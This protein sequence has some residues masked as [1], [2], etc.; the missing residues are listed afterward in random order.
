MEAKGI[1]I[2]KDTLERTSSAITREMEQ[3]NQSARG[4]IGSGVNLASPE[5]VCAI[6]L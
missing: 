4:L 1:A 3:L 2:S 6:S 5:Q